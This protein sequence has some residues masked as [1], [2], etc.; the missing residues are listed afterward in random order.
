MPS[1][2]VAHSLPCQF[3]DISRASIAISGGVRHPPSR[4]S[5]FLSE[6][7]GMNVFLKT[8]L[9]QFTG[10]FKER[11]ARYTLLSLQ[12]QWQHDPS[13]AGNGVIAASAGNHA[14]AL[15]YHGSLLKVPVTVVMPSVAP[16]AKVDKC[17][18]FGARVIIQGD[19]IGESKLYA[20][21][22]MGEEGLV[23]VNGYDDKTIIAGAGSVGIEMCEEIP[24]LD[25]VIV[26]V[27]G[28]GLIAGVSCAV[29][30]LRPNCYVYGV[31]PENAAS[32][33]AALK[34]GEPVPFPVE[35]TLADGLA[36]PTVG[37]Q[38]FQVAREYV[39]QTFLASERECAIACLRLIENEK[40]VVEGAGA[41][42][43]T[44]ILPGGALDLPENKGKT[45]AIPICGG[46]ID[47]T[48]LGRVID[49][50]L[51]ADYRLVRFVATVSD[52][53]GGIA[54]LT[55]L[56]A[57][58]G[59][60][61]KDIY[62]ERAWLHSSVSNVQVKCVVE[63]QGKEHATRLRDELRS[64]GYAVLWDEELVDAGDIKGVKPTLTV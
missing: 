46:N 21:S 36:V 27:G 35:S 47:T 13:T 60:S 3:T 29:K 32:Y 40:M 54:K 38:A 61:I 34:A 43:L 12:R 11:G 56:L 53:P 51:A 20:E 58:S 9:D 23:Y 37:P 57:S 33:T 5:Y 62:H 24:D 31:E 22:I 17:R 42:G 52:R 55:T 39:D 59:A 6:L 4:R 63:L 48:T 26:P 44:P 8:E 30:T 18:K 64:H 45:V 19:H 15:A 7:T 28:A 49:R 41:L 50:G 16:L 10:S 25:M 1:D 14:L 2:E